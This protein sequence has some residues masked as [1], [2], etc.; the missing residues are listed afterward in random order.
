LVR[1]LA[2]DVARAHPAFPARAFLRDTTGGLEALE[3]L[4]RG[5]HI[6]RA[7]FYLPHM[8]FVAAPRV[9]WLDAHPERS[10]L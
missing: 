5:R 6:M 7:F 3:L 10:G 1:R 2:A 4:D 9:A 8:L